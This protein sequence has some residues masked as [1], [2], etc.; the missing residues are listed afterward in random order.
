MTVLIRQPLGG[1]SLYKFQS[2]IKDMIH[3]KYKW[4]KRKLFARDNTTDKHSFHTL[5]AKLISCVVQ[6]IL[7]WSVT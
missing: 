7:G 6:E 1:V 3:M 5:F 4:H 2:S